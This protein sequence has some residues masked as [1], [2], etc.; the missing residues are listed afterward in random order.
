MKKIFLLFSLSFLLLFAKSKPI[1]L[2]FFSKSVSLQVLGSG[3]PEMGDKRASSAYLIWINER[4][5]I[6]IDFGG[7]ASLRFEEVE[8][9]IANLDVILLTNLH[10][11]HTADLPALLKASFFTR[12]SGVLDI[13]GPFGNDIM[14]NTRGFINKLFIANRGAW[15]YL[16]DHLNGGAKLQLK[17]HNVTDDK[18]PKVIYD[19]NGIRI[20]AVSVH[21]GSIPSI[22]YRVEV[23]SKS[24]T[25]SGDMNGDYNTLESLAKDSDIL[26]ANNAIPKGAGEKARNLYITPFKIGEIA[27]KA[28]VKSVVLSHRMLRTLGKEKLQRRSRVC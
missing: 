1:S 13:Y 18:K 11:D 10:S 14:P 12:A 16:S 4:S 7:G 15:E 21:H 28:R 5:R 19:K 26:V 24:V 20:I 22:A 25:F 23:G 6:L 2:P 3:G 9:N 17:S 8:A 27:Q